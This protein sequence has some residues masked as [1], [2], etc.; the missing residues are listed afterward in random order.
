MIYVG[1]DDTDIVGSPGTN[2]LARA[3]LKRLGD[4]AAGA[5]IVRHQLFFDPRVPYTSKNGS[6]SIQL[7]CL[8]ESLE[9]WLVR[10]IT[11]V[12]RGWYVEGS[13]PGLCVAA[14]VSEEMAA[15]GARC[16]CEVVTKE[17]AREVA[18][19]SGARLE[20]LGGTEQGIIG[21]LAAIGLVASGEDG[22]VVHLASWPYPDDEFHGPQ[23]IR[24][25][26]ARGIELV[27]AVEPDTPIERGRVDI[28]KHLRPN[29]H[30]HRIV[31]F[32][33]PTGSPDIPWR[34]LKLN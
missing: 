22:R 21:A 34:A 17:E 23:D 2:Q 31:L 9:N 18:K 30:G 16:K 12:M 25:L 14:R 19:R 6:A 10:Q 4:D 11:D 3:I 20:G 27:R 5:V 8:H 24:E 7:P 33:E 15:F 32:V 1:I 28:G 29:V 26:R 13:D